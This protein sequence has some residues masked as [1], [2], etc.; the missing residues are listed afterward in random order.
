MN[1]DYVI[2]LPQ[3]DDDQILATDETGAELLH[4]VVKWA[5]KTVRLHYPRFGQW[6]SF[7]QDV[8]KILTLIGDGI[9]KVD[10]DIAQTD[11][12]AWQDLCGRFIFLHE[13]YPKIHKAFFTYLRPT[14]DDLDERQ[15]A[16]WLS[17]NAPLDAVVRMFCALLTPQ[18]MLKKNA[19][20]AL[21]MIF[22]TSLGQHYTPTSTN[23]GAGAKNELIPA[24]SSQFGSFY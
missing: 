8:Y 14:V 1:D 13:V 4:F 10:V 22:Q 21:S 12:D 15:A 3:L 19:R 2:S 17:Q 5:G 9:D 20:F 16:A 24:P 7:C 18:A 11:K 23:S 6:Q